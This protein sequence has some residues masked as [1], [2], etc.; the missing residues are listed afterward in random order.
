MEFNNPSI[1]QN[2]YLHDFVVITHKIYLLPY[3]GG[4]E[5]EGGIYI[6]KYIQ[7]LLHITCHV[8]T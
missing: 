8:F 4:G 5:G 2:L 3:L 6:I 1:Y 7:C